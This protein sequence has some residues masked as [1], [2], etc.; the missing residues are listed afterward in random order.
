MRFAGIETQDAL[1][2]FRSPSIGVVRLTCG[3]NTCQD[4]VR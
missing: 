1:A 2:D 3:L 4:P